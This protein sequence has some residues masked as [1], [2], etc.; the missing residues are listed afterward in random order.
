MLCRQLCTTAVLEA[1]PIGFDQFPPFKTHAETHVIQLKHFER[2]ALE[3]PRLDTEYARGSMILQDLKS[4]W[5]EYSRTCI[6]DINPC[7]ISSIDAVNLLQ[8]WPT[9]TVDLS[10]HAEIEHICSSYQ[11]V[12]E[13]ECSALQE[14]ASMQSASLP[15]KYQLDSDKLHIGVPDVALKKQSVEILKKMIRC[16]AQISLLLQ[17]NSSLDIFNVMKKQIFTWNLM[18]GEI[19]GDAI[20]P[21]SEGMLQQILLPSCIAREDNSRLDSACETVIVNAQQMFRELMQ[22]FK[23]ST[24]SKITALEISSLWDEENI[25][26]AGAD[27]IQEKPEWDIPSAPKPACPVPDVVD[28][29]QVEQPA[30]MPKFHENQGDNQ[31]TSRRNKQQ[32]DI[33]SKTA[34]VQILD[35]KAETNLEA[36]AKFVDD[37]PISTDDLVNSFFCADESNVIVTADQDKEPSRHSE[38]VTNSKQDQVETDK[39]VYQLTRPVLWD[40]VRKKVMRVDPVNIQAALNQIS[41][42]VL[43]TIIF[44]LHA[45]VK[46]LSLNPSKASHEEIVDACSSFRQVVWLHSLRYIY[47]LPL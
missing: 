20:K 44:K 7:T 35:D 9:N 32:H 5:C 23:V 10:L 38:K 8:E 28:E 16:N 6:G 25:M 29:L 36:N 13:Q 18:H 14:K 41:L 12:D 46:H 31:E 33:S 30:A 40:L 22:Q 1:D 24:A 11:A 17:S 3:I 4:K 42:D 26:N 45:K 21:S 15:Q 19:A 37:T 2:K 39:L 27:W 47:I 43:E 34:K